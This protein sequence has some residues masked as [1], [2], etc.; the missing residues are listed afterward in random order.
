MSKLFSFLL[1]DNTG[2]YYRGLEGGGHVVSCPSGGIRAQSSVMKA[3][4][5]A[6]NLSKF[7]GVLL[8]LFFYFPYILSLRD[9]KTS[10]LVEQAIEITIQCKYEM[11][12]QY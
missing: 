4:R 7:G 2:K 1:G 8:L 11:A 3:Y 9:W 6:W 12:Q 5:L 10:D